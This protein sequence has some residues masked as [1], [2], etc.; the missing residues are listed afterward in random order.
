[1]NQTS[2]PKLP[3]LTAIWQNTLNWQPTPAQ[4]DLFQQLFELILE[5]NQQ[6]NLTRLTEPEEF[7]EKHLWDSLRGIAPILSGK[8]A[9]HPSDKIIDIGTGGGFPGIPVALVLPDCSVTLLDSTRKKI[10][11]LTTILEQLNFKN[12]IPW[13][14]RAEALGQHHKHRESYQLALLRAVAPPSVSAEYALPLLKIGGLGILYRGHWTTE[15]EKQLT[16]AVKQLGGIIESVDEFT[17]PLTNSV[18]HCV[19]IKKVKP[20]PKQYPRNVGVPGQKPL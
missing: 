6:L 17:T 20:T 5:F 1:M 10:T 4:Q 8:T 11:A 2:F 16:S 14:G 9:S 13:V 7:W 12:T 15:E 3:E 18:R 19:S